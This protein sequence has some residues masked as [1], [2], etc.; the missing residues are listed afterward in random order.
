MKFRPV[1][2]KAR[3]TPTVKPKSKAPKKDRTDT[4]SCVRKGCRE[5]VIPGDVAC[6]LHTS[7]HG[8]GGWYGIVPEWITFSKPPPMAVLVWLTLWSYRN[9]NPKKNRTPEGFP[10]VWPSL[11]GMAGKLGCSARTVQ[12]GI[13]YLVEKGHIEKE[14]R[15]GKTTLYILKFLL[16]AE[17]IENL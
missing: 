3:S 15:P 13:D 10:K 8:D 9:H 4:M 17:E 5:P 7:A 14:E 11:A 12:R 6:A 1:P 16:P 2:P